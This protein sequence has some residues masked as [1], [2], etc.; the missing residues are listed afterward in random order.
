[1]RGFEAG[2]GEKA[3]TDA[4]PLAIQ[5]LKTSLPFI[6]RVFNVQAASGGADAWTVPRLLELGP[7]SI[8]NRGRL[9]TTEDYEW[10]ILERFS[11]VARVRCLATRAPGPGG[12][13]VF[14]AGAV[15]VI[16]VPRS[17]E[18][19]PQPSQRLIRQIRDFLARTA[20]AAIDGDIHVKGPDYTEV[21]VSAL[22]TPAVPELSNV[23]LRRAAAEL[24]GFL[25]PLTGG[26]DRTGYGFGRAVYLSEVQAVL[27]RIDGV[28]HVEEAVFLG[29]GP[30]VQSFLVSENSLASSGI[31]DIRLV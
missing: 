5:E 1:M 7:Q 26:E 12:E 17:A 2:G 27:E 24:E 19:R 10:M 13:L 15:T 21:S 8:K 20:L 9:V 3:N 22:L 30:G 14:K 4:V 29:A 23:I 25:H 11:Q 16:V 31:H 6:D 18:R 28:D